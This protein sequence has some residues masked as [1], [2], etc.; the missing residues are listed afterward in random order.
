MLL[1]SLIDSS[2]N[3]LTTRPALV[4][5]PDLPF[6]GTRI[7]ADGTVGLERKKTRAFLRELEQR[8]GATARTLTYVDRESIG[9]AICSVVNRSLDP[10]S[11]LTQQRSAV[12]LR[13]V[14]TDRRQLEQLDYWIARL[15]LRAVTGRRDVSAFREI[16]YRKL[17]HDWGL[18]S[19]VAARNAWPRRL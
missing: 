14:V 16:H 13:R 9:R 15:V 1:C 5:P 18:V 10:R 11:A 2:I 3:K 7:A 12:L 19:L 8:T 6:L 4:A 17:R